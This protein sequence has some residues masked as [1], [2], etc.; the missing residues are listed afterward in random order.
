MVAEKV[1][2]IDV[3]YLVTLEWEAKM[4]SSKLVDGVVA[5]DLRM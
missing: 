5:L 1:Q 3:G 4:R 2:L